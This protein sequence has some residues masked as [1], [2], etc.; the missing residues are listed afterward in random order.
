MAAGK[1]HAELAVLDLRIQ[2]E[3]INTGLRILAADRPFLAR[4]LSRL[5]AA[6]GIEHL[7]LGD[8][9][10]PAAGLSGIP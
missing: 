3:F 7:V 6:Q 4:S 10:N 2:K 1:H 9:V 5:L 8:A